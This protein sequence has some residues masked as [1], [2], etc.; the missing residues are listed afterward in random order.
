MRYK[1][2]NPDNPYNEQP[3][4]AAAWEIGWM[5]RQADTDEALKATIHWSIQFRQ[6]LRD[7][8]F[9]Y[10]PNNPC[11]TDEELIK[12]VRELVKAKLKD[13]KK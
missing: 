8:I 3:E 11:S 9:P 12:A 4:L 10:Y 7:A 5:A 1:L 13:K 6:A 2:P